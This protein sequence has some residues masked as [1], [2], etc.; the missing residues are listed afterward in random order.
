VVPSGSHAFVKLA[1][2]SDKQLLV[3]EGLFHELLNEPEKKQVVADVV[4]WL[5]ARL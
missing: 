3:Y 5:K 4:H 2:S 1:A